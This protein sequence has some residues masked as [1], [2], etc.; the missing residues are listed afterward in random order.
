MIKSIIDG[1]S[2]GL[3][4]KFGNEYGIYTE[5][6]N[7]GLREPCFFIFCINSSVELFPS[8]RKHKQLMFCIHYIPLSDEKS[9]EIIDVAERLFECLRY[10]TV[11]DSL[12]LGTK[13]SYKIVDEVLHF[14]VNYDVFVYDTE[15]KQTM[16][17][18]KIKQEGKSNE[19]WTKRK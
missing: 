17:E 1:I 5:S 2:L 3:N 13:M 11:N 7:Q 14:Y 18:L 8:K 12:V 6:I 9:K 4:A 16:E 15:E 19:G 10:I